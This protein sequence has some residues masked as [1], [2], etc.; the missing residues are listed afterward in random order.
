MK[1]YENGVYVEFTAEELAV[2]ES[3]KRKT[4]LME[5]SRPLTADEVTRILL[6]QQVNTL[7]VDDNTA[8]RMV[9]FYPE[10][11]SGVAYTVGYKVRYG[12]K[13]W[14][15]RQA[16]SSQ[17]GWE[18]DIVPALWEQVCE[19]HDGTLDDPIPYDGNMALEEGKYYHQDYVIYRCIRNTVNP[20][21]HALS[22]LVGL[23][24]EEV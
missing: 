14:R 20:V 3:E 24:V 16:H 6:T 12:G 17:A 5:R 11:A 15:V 1:R 22:E 4:D 21:Y 2:I 8:L 9:E 18:P 23:Y 13:L 7:N 19:S 10:W